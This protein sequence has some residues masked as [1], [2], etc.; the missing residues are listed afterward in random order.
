MLKILE[1]SFN[2]DWVWDL[3]DD[4]GFLVWMDAKANELASKWHYEVAM[5]ECDVKVA[6]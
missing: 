3:D 4:D 1:N 2:G 6:L 5:S